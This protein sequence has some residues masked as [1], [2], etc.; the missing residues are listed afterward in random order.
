M[1]KNLTLLTVAA[2]STLFYFTASVFVNQ[3]LF[4][5]NFEES[6]KLWLMPALLFGPITTLIGRK[7]VL[8][9]Y[10]LGA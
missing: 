4:E 1:K 10:Q 8:K 3:F 2:C 9:R 5:A 6:T 7:K